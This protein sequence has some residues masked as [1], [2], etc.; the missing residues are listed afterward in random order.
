ML[1]SLTNIL[2]RLLYGN[3]RGEWIEVERDANSIASTPN[4]LAECLTVRIVRMHFLKITQAS[5][6]TLK[7]TAFSSD[8]RIV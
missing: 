3:K 7:E 5:Y 1:G 8:W 4:F 2:Y 6:Y